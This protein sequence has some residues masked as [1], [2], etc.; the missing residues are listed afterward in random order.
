MAEG[1]ACIHNWKRNKVD[2]IQRNTFRQNND[3]CIDG[4]S[5]YKEIRMMEVKNE[6]GKKE[7]QE[8]KEGTCNL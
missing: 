1:P 6:N 4:I 8:R 5:L 3:A 7:N 2:R